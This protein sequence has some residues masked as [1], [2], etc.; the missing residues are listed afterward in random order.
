MSPFHL[1]RIGTGLPVADVIGKLQAACAQHHA[2]VVQAPPGT[3]KT[4]LVPPLLANE[5]EG[6]VLVVAP[7]R[8]AVRAA[9][10]RLAHLDGSRIGDR[11][12]FRIRGES[13]PGSRVEF[14]TPGVLLR[15]LLHDPEL[16]GVS[17]VVL[18]EVH[19]RQLDTDLALGMLIELRELRDDLVIVAMSATL[20]AQTLARL[21]DAPIVQAHAPIHELSIRYVPSTHPRTAVSRDFLQEVATLSAQ[22]A[23]KSEHSVL[24]FVPGKREV[25]ILCE[26][27]AQRTS[28]AVFALHG[29]LSSR[30]QDA[31]LGY[32]G[33]RIVVATSIAESS[34][35]VPGVRTVIDTGLAR[36]PKRDA[37][38]GINGLVTLSTSQ[39]SAEQRAGR[40][41]RE[42]PGSVIRCY[43]QQDFSRFAPH[44]TPEINAADLTQAMLTLACWGT[45]D[46]GTFPFLSPPPA[47][48]VRDARDTLHVLG[49]LSSTGVATEHGRAL[50]SLPLAPRLGS[51]L[52]QCGE[53]AADTVAA[54]SLDAA[55][56]LSRINPSKELEREARRLA[57]LAPPSTTHFTPGQ[58]IAHAFPQRI[59]RASAKEGEFLL[60]S[61][62]RARLDKITALAGCEWI[63]VAG[64][65]LN[66]Q[67]D[68]LISAAAPLQQAEAEAIAGVQERTTATIEAGRIKATRE[69]A[70]G[71][72]L[73]SS[74]PCSLNPEEA[75]AAL[76]QH[77]QEHGLDIFHFEPA[78]KSL[79]NRLKFLYE[80]VGDPW[81]DVERMSA[82][83]LEAEIAQL[84]QG[85]PPAK[86]AMAP[87]LKRILPWPEAAHL[88]ELVP[89]T[90]SLPSGNQ[91]SIDYQDR[92]VVAAKL[93]ECFG[94]TQ[95]PLIC[96]QRVLFH[97]LS[98]AGRPL[99]LTDD[100]AS[101]WAGPYQG[102]RAEMRG[103][104]PK[105]P[106]PEDP[107]QAQ[108][109][110]KTNRALR[111]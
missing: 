107:L 43:S 97:L 96:G 77:V 8:V 10:R 26:L 60:A 109:T 75:K 102:V 13:H 6:L 32:E 65:R 105:H 103:R 71:A 47:P 82:S 79:W 98:P 61:G 27:L 30:E 92:P 68:A 64:L 3:G 12:G 37:A 9:A 16:A 35:T 50:A 41:G 87:V 31:A 18:D 17:A 80:H 29:Q 70:L 22:A 81:P 63:A 24:V 51:A 45:T 76:T 62:T 69:R 83:V 46:L 86:I 19:E 28:L 101:F 39:A 53:K 73:L 56:D 74:T 7:R 55:G 89:A 95:T 52:L 25:H 85:V 33:Q 84:A 78:A 100:L 59:A 1:E 2:A 42:G 15:R 57:A 88:D 110:A 90:L 94:L 40:A 93:Q 14:L 67:G 66:A 104:Y 21:M 72:I 48:A 36:V 54:I 58:V 111:S 4:T 11:V 20:E 5:V 108:A 38:R 23:H 106:W 49:A 44:S 91:A 99:A 34:I